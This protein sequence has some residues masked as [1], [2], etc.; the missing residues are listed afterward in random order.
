MQQIKQDYKKMTH[1]HSAR[2]KLVALLQVNK[3]QCQVFGST[4]SMSRQSATGY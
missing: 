2:Y 1:S 3:I 4:L